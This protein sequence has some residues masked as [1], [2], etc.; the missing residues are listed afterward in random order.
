MLKVAEK[1][2]LGKGAAFVKSQL[3]RLRQNDDMWEADFGVFEEGGTWLG[4]V[5]SPPS[6]AILAGQFCEHLPTVNDLATL[7]AHAMRRPALGSPSRPRLV[8]LTDN[9]AWAELVP[10]LQ[11]VGVEVENLKRL[12]ASQTA[13]R[14][15]RQELQKSRR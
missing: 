8:R 7:L 13:L 3:R 15:F 4:V 14:E 12:Q 9:P 2:K 1:L 5:V 6:G 11:E 10:H